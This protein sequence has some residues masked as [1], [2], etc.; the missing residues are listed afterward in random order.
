VKVAVAPARDVAAPTPSATP[1]V[2]AVQTAADA[3]LS[4]EAR[5]EEIQRKAKSLGYRARTRAGVEVFCRTEARLG[6][7][8]AEET[9]IRPE[10]V[11]GEFERNALMKADM[12]A[13]HTCGGA[14]CS[15]H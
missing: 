15:A 13:H 6:T 14:G 11:D 3:A 12:E 7:R 4:P 9:C 8:F 10:Q 2:A 1:A 5:N